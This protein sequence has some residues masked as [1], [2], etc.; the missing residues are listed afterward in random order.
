MAYAA[1]DYG[2]D[3]D[4]VSRRRPEQVCNAVWHVARNSAGM[5][6]IARIRFKRGGA[7]ALGE[8]S[9]ELFIFLVAVHWIAASRLE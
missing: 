7:H 6:R 1:E 5:L 3:F 2:V 8:R 4:G 9:L